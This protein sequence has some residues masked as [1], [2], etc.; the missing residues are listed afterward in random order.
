M[1]Q[2]NFESVKEF[3]KGMSLLDAAK[4]VK[5]LE[6]ELGVSAAAPVGMMAAMPAAGGAGAELRGRD[7]GP[8]A[9]AGQ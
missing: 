6:D 1:S 2:V 3:I 8:S 9:G 4:L 7:R 5:D